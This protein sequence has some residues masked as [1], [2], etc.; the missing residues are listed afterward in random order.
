MN[1]YEIETNLAT[2]N[3]SDRCI[4]H[5]LATSAE[6]AVRKAVQLAR[7]Q[8]PDRRVYDVVKL[9]LIGSRDE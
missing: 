3:L 7:R 8:N 6:K 1:I 5:V 4:W 2:S 9:T